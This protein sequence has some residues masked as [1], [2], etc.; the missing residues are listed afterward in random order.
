[1][2]VVGERGVVSGGEG[3]GSPLTNEALPW[4]KQHSR[5]FFHLLNWRLNV[6]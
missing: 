2:M 1:M 5:L 6:Q 4:V 3:W